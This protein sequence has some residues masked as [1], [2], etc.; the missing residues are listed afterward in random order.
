MI[1]H[2]MVAEKWASAH[3]QRCAVKNPKGFMMNYFINPEFNLQY[4]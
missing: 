1:K 2:M 4:L 3:L